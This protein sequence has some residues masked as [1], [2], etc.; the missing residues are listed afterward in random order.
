M[1]R[2]AVYC[3]PADP[4]DWTGPHF[5][6]SGVTAEQAAAEIAA[7]GH[8]CP[9]CRATTGWTFELLGGS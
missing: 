6:A 1:P 2:F 9:D 7:H 3:V 5:I 8:R 4:A